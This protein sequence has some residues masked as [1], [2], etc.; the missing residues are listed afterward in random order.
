MQSIS[1]KGVREHETK[2]KT[3][4][5]IVIAAG[6]DLVVPGNGFNRSGK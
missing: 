3:K 5:D 4:Q 2:K 1:E 6:S